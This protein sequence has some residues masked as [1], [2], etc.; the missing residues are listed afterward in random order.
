L[1]FVDATALHRR[2]QD[3]RELR[4]AAEK[5]DRERCE[6]AT[7]RAAEDARLVGVAGVFSDVLASEDSGN[8]SLRETLSRYCASRAADIVVVGSRGFGSIHRAALHIAGFGSVS[9]HLMRHGTWATLLVKR[10]GEVVDVDGKANS[11]NSAK[12][13]AAKEEVDTVGVG[14]A[15]E[16]K[17][18]PTNDDGGGGGGGARDAK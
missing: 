5:I 14:S 7:T 9:E 12:S 11:A 15:D 17:M 6:K 1:C 2:K 10:A 8:A 18:K 16:R 4:L 13:A 3:Q